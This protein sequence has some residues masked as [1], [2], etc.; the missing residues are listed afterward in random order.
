MI[1]YLLF[2]F[3]FFLK[4]NNNKKK[5]N[6]FKHLQIFSNA[7]LS[8]SLFQ[9]IGVFCLCVFL[10]VSLCQTSVN[11]KKCC[12]QNS[13]CFSKKTVYYEIIFEEEENV[14]KE[15]I[16]EELKMK[17]TKEI[18]KKLNDQNLE[19]CFDIPE[20]VIKDLNGKNS[21]EQME[22]QPA[23][24]EVK[25]QHLQVSPNILFSENVTH[26]HTFPCVS[27]MSVLSVLCECLEFCSP[28]R[29][30]IYD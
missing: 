1:L 9:I 4:N 14:F 13:T 12:Q 25:N 24:N 10:L 29:L 11:W 27:F 17:L 26:T 5:R 30:I 8:D 20:I 28:P 15:I 18:K 3:L 6:P 22:Q 7:I 2:F 21:T 19:E 23:N 16:R